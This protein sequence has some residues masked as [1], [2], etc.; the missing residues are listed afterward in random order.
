[1]TEETQDQVLKL[2]SFEVYINDEGVPYRY[3]VTDEDVAEQHGEDSGLTAYILYHELVHTCLL[4][5]ERHDENYEAV[6]HYQETVDAQL[7]EMQGLR[8]VIQEIRDELDDVINT[9]EK[10][11][12]E[13]R[14]Q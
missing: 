9:Y 7:E 8:M 11:L 14:E 4:M 5:K 12:N 1:M 6:K 13:L 10:Q 2:K 3:E